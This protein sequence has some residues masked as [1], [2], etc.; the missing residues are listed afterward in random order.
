MKLTNE[1]IMESIGQ[2]KAV[3]ETNLDGKIHSNL[4]NAIQLVELLIQEIIEASE[5]KDRPEQSMK[6]VGKLANNF[7]IEMKEH[8]SSSIEY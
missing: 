3:G 7:L 1:Q 8:I 6:I 5:D 4:Q 2:L